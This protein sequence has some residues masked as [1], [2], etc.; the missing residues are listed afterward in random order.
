MDVQRKN[1]QLFFGLEA[2]DSDENSL[3]HLR[4]SHCCWW[5]LLENLFPPEEEEG[6]NLAKPRK[7]RQ[8][9]T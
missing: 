9:S 2:D 6:E 1:H 8:K 5:C 4:K 3:I 7:R